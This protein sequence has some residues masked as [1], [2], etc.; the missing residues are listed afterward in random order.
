[1]PQVGTCQGRKQKQKN[2]KRKEP[3]FTH[4]CDTCDRGFKNKEKYEEHTSQHKQCTEDGCNFRAHEKLV[5]IHWKNMHSPGAK[6]IKLDTP[7]EIARWREERKKNFPTLANIE[8]KKALKMEKEC[9]GEVLTT[10]QFGKMKGMWKPQ[11]EVSRQQ[12]NTQRRTNWC[13]NKSREVSNDKDF[14][15][16]GST[17]TGPNNHGAEEKIRREPSGDTQDSITDRDPLSVLAS[18]DPELDK[19]AGTSRDQALGTSIVPNQVTPALSSLVVNYGSL[20]ESESEQDEAI[21]PVAKT[22]A[23]NEAIPRNTPQSSNNSQSCEQEDHQEALCYPYKGATPG[24]AKSHTRSTRNLKRQK[25]SLPALRNHHP[26]LLEMLLA[27]DIR[28]ER[29]VILQ[30]IRYILQ[31]N[32]LG[33]H[34][35]TNSSTLLD[36]EPT[37]W[38]AKES[39]TDKPCKV[40]NSLNFD[41]NKTKPNELFESKEVSASPAVDEDVWESTAITCKDN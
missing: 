8:K 7:D 1:M 12:G 26:T 14:P 37:P 39:A 30:C 18:S 25:K 24:R 5:Q 40:I 36:S 19:E 2:K 34:L 9:R 13:Y 6:R 29:N 11:Y 17:V 35:E 3:V 16:N 20:S 22:V 41:Q 21:T 10:L 32:G 33:P 28:H 31:N 27:K 4:Y 23:E 38:H 15:L